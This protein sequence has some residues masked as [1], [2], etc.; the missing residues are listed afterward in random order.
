MTRGAP[1]TQ[2][3]DWLACAAIAGLVA[4][5]FARTAGHEFVALDDHVYLTEN[6]VVQ[7]GLSLE[8]ARWAMTTG[9]ASNWHPLTWLSHMVDWQ[10]F[11]AWA[12]GHH[13]VSFAL[14]AGN[15]CLVYFVLRTILTLARASAGNRDSN[16][17][18]I[19]KGKAEAR[20]AQSIYDRA[21]FWIA[22]MVAAVYA[23]HPLRV[24]S[25]AWASERKDVLC[26]LFW[27]SAVL[28]Y[29]RSFAAG[30]GGPTVLRRLFVAALLAIGLLAKPMLVSLPAVLMLLD[31]W[32]LRRLEGGQRTKGLSLTWP[33]AV[34]EALAKW[35]LWLLVMVSSVVTFQ[36]QRAGGAVLEA[37]RYPLGVKLAVVLHAYAKYLEQTV[38]PLGLCAFYPIPV[39]ELAP[40]GL[41]YGP[42]IVSAAVLTAVTAVC[43]GQAGRRPYLLVGWLWYLVTLIPVIGLVK[44][45]DPFHADRYTYLPQFGL[46]LWAACAVQEL[47]R[48]RPRLA[49]PLAALGAG[50]LA[51]LAVL[52]YRQVGTWRDTET[53][54][55]RALAVTSENHM[56]HYLLG[57]ALA[58]RDE[59]RPAMEQFD[60]ALRYNPTDFVARFDLATYQLEY[61]LVDQ[62]ERNMRLVVQD[63]PNFA[64]GHVG[65]A[66]AL[67]KRRAH[68]EVLAALDA[69]LQL[70]DRL[71]T[72]H[73]GR[74]DVLMALQRPREAAD[75]YARAAALRSSHHDLPSDD[76]TVK[77][78]EALVRSDQAAAA[79]KLLQAH[80]AEPDHATAELRGRA[81]YLLGLAQATLQRP[82]EAATTWK[83]ALDE[84]PWRVDTA[85]DLA[86][87]LATSPDATLHDGPLAARIAGEMCSRINPTPAAL[88]DTLAA[89]QAAAG[90]FAGAL[91]TADRALREVGEDHELARQLSQRRALYE[92]KQAYREGAK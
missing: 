28:F 12:G 44:V 74:G 61:G 52:C 34:R 51:L 88:L 43:V 16:N 79:E 13:L 36:V 62:A 54:A 2:R 71:A 40:Q 90:D 38:L 6:P 29:L 7:R 20:P 73:V 50:T 53:L 49:R 46:L 22:L 27:W 9:T 10:V 85:N 39:R 35:P 76:W 72:A 8:G 89:A 25:V 48:G 92:Q 55:R 41:A 65:L 19:K 26:S 82:R 21:D 81:S 75:A 80:L 58:R 91:A 59:K 31:V 42:A 87:L 57:T 86:W 60:L 47:L 77:Q 17:P 56:A 37:E 70:D 1:A 33:L 84:L 63:R 18:A 24:E 68:V 66:A 64:Q 32:P 14:H 83:R 69:A 45:V 5:V 15:A 3:N 30:D 4:S 67:G 11:G 78:A 23:V